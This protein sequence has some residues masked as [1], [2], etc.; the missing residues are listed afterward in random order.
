VVN[1]PLNV[2][3]GGF[4][5]RGA[6]SVT[7]NG[8]ATAGNL[9]V[10]ILSGSII[11]GVA[12]CLGANAALQINTGSK[13]NVNGNHQTVASLSFDNLPQANGTWG[14]SSSTA[15]N[16]NDTFFS[17]TGVM[18]VGA[19]PGGYSSW[20]ATNA[21]SGTP[22]DDYDGDGVSNGVEYVLGGSKD[23]ND[24][25][26]LPKPT[27]SGTDL[28]FTFVRDQQ[29]IDGTTALTIETGT[30]LVTWPNSYSVPNTAA[31]ANPGV[32]V[33]KGVPTARKDTIVLTVPSAPDAKKF[34]RLNVVI[35]P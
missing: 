11:A 22:Q 34:A 13:L 21:P 32:P 8:T 30:N 2:G 18:Q 23:T 35:T 16:K 15:T 4:F 1:G 7:L 9:G 28:V 24:L 20:A 29:S 5:K 26:K 25:D 6:G 33:T 10:R 17:G 27:I 31:V 14:S 3:S 19:L 12:E